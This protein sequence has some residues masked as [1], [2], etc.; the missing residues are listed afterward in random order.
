MVPCVRSA[1]GEDARV[2]PCSDWTDTE[3]EAASFADARLHRRFAGLLRQLAAGV[4]TPIPQACG[5]WAGTKAAYRFLSNRRV[6]E[7][8]ILGGHMMATT[9]RFRACR[10]VVLLLQDTTEF[11]YRRV[12][13]SAIGVTKSVNSGRD[14]EGR[15]RHHTLCG[16]LLHTSLAVT[17]DGVPLGVTALKVW[18]RSKFKG[19]AALKRAVNPTRVPI[20]GKESIR[21][22]DSLQGSVDLLGDPG[23]C[24]HVADRESDIYELFCLARD[25]GTHFIV[26]T[27][28]DRR[29]GD[30]SHTVATEMA[31]ARVRG[32]HRVE[33]RG[34]E[35]EAI[36]AVLEIR[37]R[38]VQVLPPIGKQRRYPA[39]DLTVLHVTERHPP[40]G[41]RPIE[42]K[43]L[44][45]LPV[46]SREEAIE[47][48]RWYAM[49]W[50]IETFHK[51]LKSGCRVEESRLRCAERIANLLALFCIIAWRILWLTL[52]HRADPD[53][54]PETALR[55]REIALLD[56]L[57]PGVQSEAPQG[58]TL[59]TYVRMLARLGGH[60]GRSRDPPPG[61]IV[62]WRGLSRLAD[63]ELGAEIAGQPS[64]G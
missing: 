18:T 37:A 53:A 35:G 33:L 46:R 55:E 38:R 49:R 47:K 58:K 21:W 2:P 45:D 51:I 44:T 6:G 29:V 34:A 52:A 64:C 11:T 43:L 42:W 59:A 28:V 14:A 7:A 9:E 23:R 57:T 32:L 5:D 12:S 16:L 26:R 62:L 3:V 31:E 60:L 50:K 54:P 13:T 20:E 17:E 22:L 61:I 27:C 40:R 30:G 8:E 4:G 39:L 24:I 48:L 19:T 15:W 63:I 10:E 41:R 25:L 1:A 36:H 56:R